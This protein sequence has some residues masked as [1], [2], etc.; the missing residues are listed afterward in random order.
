M[1]RQ[2]QLH[3]SLKSMEVQANA[4]AAA[5]KT[6]HKKGDKTNATVHSSSCSATCTQRP[7]L[8]G[9]LAVVNP[10]TCPSSFSSAT[11]ATVKIRRGQAHLG[12]SALDR[13]SESITT[14]RDIVRLEII[15]KLD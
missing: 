2:L 11:C 14:R 13:P 7:Q 1:T 15:P 4:T 6:H 3:S 12:W 8:G 5:T 9:R 10:T